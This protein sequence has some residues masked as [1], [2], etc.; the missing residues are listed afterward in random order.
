MSKKNKANDVLDAS[1][2]SAAAVH[3]MKMPSVETISMTRLWA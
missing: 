1:L 3:A 2:I